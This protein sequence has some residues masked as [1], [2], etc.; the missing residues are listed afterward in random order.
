MF[1]PCALSSAFPATVPP[2]IQSTH[3][4]LAAD[5][6]RDQD[7]CCPR[8]GSARHPVWLCPIRL[9][10]GRQMRDVQPWRGPSL[11][12]S[13]VDV[14]LRSS[15]PYPDESKASPSARR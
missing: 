11:Q 9:E 15:P 2:E 1:T 7:Y 8:S 10:F 5:E 13:K 3:A 14:T 4:R 6:D 12:P